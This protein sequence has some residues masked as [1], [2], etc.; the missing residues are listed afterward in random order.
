MSRQRRLSSYHAE[1]RIMPINIAAASG[2][3]LLSHPN[4]A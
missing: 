3:A 2:T 1:F 4:S